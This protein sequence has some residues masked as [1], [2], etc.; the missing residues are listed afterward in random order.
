MDPNQAALKRAVSSGSALLANILKVMNVC[1]KSCCILVYFSGD[2]LELV[3][4]Y[5]SRFGDRFCCFGDLKSYLCILT[6]EE[7][8]KVSRP[9]FTQ[10]L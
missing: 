8:D 2:P 3:Q 5:F 6:P 4:N 10:I 7:V 9:I 1:Y